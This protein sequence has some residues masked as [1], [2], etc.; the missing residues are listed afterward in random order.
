MQTV[1]WVW[2]SVALVLGLGAAV[3]AFLAIGW[4]ADRRERAAYV[5]TLSVEARARLSGW[6]S[7]NTDWRL[8]RASEAAATV[9]WPET[10]PEPLPPMRSQ[11]LP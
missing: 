8:F 2:I 4:I 7:V 1:T 11:H 9:K 10:K 6:E 3:A 5:K